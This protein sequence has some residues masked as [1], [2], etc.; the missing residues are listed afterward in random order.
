MLRQIA[1][2]IIEGYSDT[3]K[4][5]WNADR[6]DFIALVDQRRVGHLK[7]V[8]SGLSQGQG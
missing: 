5:S 4:E 1:P 6:R 7:A 2:W 8:T 3:L